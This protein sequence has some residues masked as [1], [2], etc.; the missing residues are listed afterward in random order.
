[1]KTKWTVCGGRR[2]ASSMRLAR[3]LDKQ[4]SLRQR[5]VAGCLPRPAAAT[6]YRQVVCS[7]AACLNVKERRYWT[8]NAGE[9]WSATE[10]V[11]WNGRYG[12]SACS[13]FASSSRHVPAY[14]GAHFFL[15]SFQFVLDQHLKLAACTKISFYIYVCVWIFSS[16]HIRCLSST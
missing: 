16:D 6:R 8:V 10:P 1:L 14:R 5:T 4:L 12:P 13:S 2:V 11:C 7:S 3:R 9:F 15:L